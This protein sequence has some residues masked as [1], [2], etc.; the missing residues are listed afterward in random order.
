MTDNDA[1]GGVGYITRGEWHC[2]TC[3]ETGAPPPTLEEHYDEEH[4]KWRSDEWW[5]GP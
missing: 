4:P 5:D 2:V 3:G 1:D